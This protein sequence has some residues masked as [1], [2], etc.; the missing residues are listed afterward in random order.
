MKLSAFTVLDEYDAPLESRRLQDVV[1]LA[2]AAE[3][4]GLAS[5]WIA[6]HHFLPSGVCPAPPVLLA[7]CGAR[8]RHLRLGS[9]VSVLPFH[10]PIELAEQYAVLDRLLAGRL[11]LG[12][13]SGYIPAEFEG[14]GVDPT[15]KREQ[16]DRRYSTLIAALKGEE[17]RG[18]GPRAKPVRLNVRPVQIPH[19]P[20]WIAVQRREAVPFVARRGVSIALI[21]YAT[22]GG[23]DEL[24]SEIREFRAQVP[25]GTHA[26]VAVALHL[27]AGDRPDRAR[28]ALQRYLDSRR[29]TQSTFYLEKVRAE[30]RHAG[31]RA[32]EESGWAI[33]GTARDVAA[34]L[35]E[36][37]EVGVDELLGLFDFGG[38]PSGEVATSMMHLAEG[39]SPLRR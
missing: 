32:I 25:S 17:V 14:F 36:F 2:E 39:F 16:F 9:L 3:R 20:I 35:S 23:I 13:G 18:E 4:A 1:E 31:A 10:S 22:L 12:V 26:E 30:P 19:P 24:R 6:E 5:L 8:T 21:P 28:S 11:N 15:S 7:A 37:A 34:R 29:A 33:F 38:L 27:Y